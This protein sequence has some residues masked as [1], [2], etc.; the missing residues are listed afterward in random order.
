[1]A[2]YCIFMLGMSVIPELR[3]LLMH[4]GFEDQISTKEASD[5]DKLF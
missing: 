2:T 4:N 5:S 1:M 3:K